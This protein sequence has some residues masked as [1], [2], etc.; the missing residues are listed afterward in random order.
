M[1]YRKTHTFLFFLFLILFSNYSYADSWLIDPSHTSITFKIRHLGVSWVRG[2]FRSAKGIITYDSNNAEATKAEI[3]IDAASINTRNERR[4][5]HLR[6]SDFFDVEN[7]PKI[8]FISSKVQ[9]LKKDGFDLIGL[10]TIRG[11]RKEIT[12]KVSDISS[13]LKRKG[14]RSKMGASGKTQIKRKDFNVSWN[15]FLDNG[16]W[17]LG[18]TV[19]ISL[20]V[21]LDKSN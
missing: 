14:R 10:L 20:D 7:H 3:T 15:R 11:I 4:D 6:S 19:H 17:V 5:R 13:V 1:L 16:G 18:N 2:E 12:I 8:Q 9:N 21:E